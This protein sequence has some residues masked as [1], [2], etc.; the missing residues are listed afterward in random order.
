MGNILKLTRDTERE[1]EFN[2]RN[3]SP[4]GWIVYKNYDYAISKT[5]IET[6]PCKHY[7]YNMSSDTGEVLNINSINRLLLWRNPELHN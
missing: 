7:V 4:F 6:N 3:P 1:I 2:N 5:C